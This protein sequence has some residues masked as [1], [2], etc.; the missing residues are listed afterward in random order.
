MLAAFELYGFGHTGALICL[1][2]ISVL[3]ILRCRKDAH[4]SHAKSALSL[5]TFCCFAAY[6]INQAAWASTGASTGAS[7]TLDAVIPLH[8]CDIAAFL[9]GFALITRRPLLCE[10]SYFWGLAGTLQGLLT[11]N[12]PYDFPHPVFAAFFLQHGV[13]VITA[14]L[15]PLGL[16]WRP[17]LG[18][19]YRAFAWL[20]GYAA[21]AFVINMALGTNFGFLMRKPNEASLLEFMPPWPFYILFM[22]C[23]G[24]LM[25]YL[26]GLPFRK[27]Y[28][29]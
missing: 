21:I 24:G 22:I 9:C 18:A 7:I 5:L 14:L 16:G 17:R 2:A 1:A 3:M 10:L 26:L 4:S 27:S 19:W 11:P 15:L 8:L 6:P 12:L 23:I 29:K 20:L 25:F 28:Q 13:V